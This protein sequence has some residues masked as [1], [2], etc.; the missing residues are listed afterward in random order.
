MCTISVTVDEAVLADANADAEAAGLNRVG[1]S[2][3]NA[4]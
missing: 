4:A 1:D 2:R 3:T